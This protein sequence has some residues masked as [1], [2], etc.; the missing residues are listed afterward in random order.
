[1]SKKSEKDKA[2]RTEA[3]KSILEKNEYSDDGKPVNTNE[4]EKNLK[5][6][7]KEGLKLTLAN[8]EQL[9]IPESEPSPDGNMIR[10]M[11]QKREAPMKQS[12]IDDTLSKAKNKNIGITKKKHSK[13]QQSPAKTI[14]SNKTKKTT[15]SKKKESAQKSMHECTKSPNAGKEQSLINLKNDDLAEKKGKRSQS[16]N[17]NVDD[18]DAD[19]NDKNQKYVE[20][21]KNSRKHDS[22]KKYSIVHK[23]QNEKSADVPLA[24][25]VNQQCD[26]KSTATKLIDEKPVDQTLQRSSKKDK[27][28]V[29][30]KVKILYKQDGWL[31]ATI[32][33]VKRRKKGETYTPVLVLLEKDNIEDE[34]GYDGEKV[35]IISDIASKQSQKSN[36]VNGDNNVLATKTNISALSI[37]NN[38]TISNLE[39]VEE[40]AAIVL[41]STVATPKS[42]QQGKSPHP[43][44]TILSDSLIKDSAPSRRF[45]FD[46]ENLSRKRICVENQSNRSSNE[47]VTEVE[48]TDGYE[49][50]PCSAAETP[51]T[52]KSVKSPNIEKKKSSM[53][54]KL[55]FGSEEDG[56]SID[57]QIERPMALQRSRGNSQSSVCTLESVKES[58]SKN[59][60]NPPKPAHTVQDGKGKEETLKT[61]QH[62]DIKS[63]KD[64]KSGANI[65]EPK[66]ND[67]QNKTG[68]SPKRT[69]R[70]KRS[71]SIYESSNTLNDHKLEIYSKGEVNAPHDVKMSALKKEN[72][73]ENATDTPKSPELR[74]S[75]RSK[76]TKISD[77]PGNKTPLKTATPNHASAKAETPLSSQTTMS[78]HSN[79]TKAAD[80]IKGKVQDEAKTETSLSSAL[81]KSPRSKRAKLSDSPGGKNPLKTTA[82]KNEK[83]GSNLLG[84]NMVKKDQTGVMLKTSPKRTTR[85]RSS[86]TEPQPSNS[87]C[88][89]SREAKKFQPRKR[90]KS[91]D[92]SKEKLVSITDTSF[93]AQNNLDFNNM[94]PGFDQTYIEESESDVTRKKRK[95][96]DQKSVQFST[97]SNLEEI[98]PQIQEFDTKFNERIEEF[99]SLVMARSNGKVDNDE[100]ESALT[101]LVQNFTPAKAKPF[102]TVQMSKEDDKLETDDFDYDADEGEIRKDSYSST[103][104]ISNCS[105]NDEM[106]WSEQETTIASLQKQNSDLDA[107]RRKII[108]NEDLYLNM[109]Q[110]WECL[111]D[112]PLGREGARMM[113]T[114]GDGRNPKPRT[115]AAVLMVRKQVCVI[116]SY[117]T[118]YQMF[119]KV[120]SSS[121][122][123][124]SI[125]NSIGS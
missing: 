18:K 74:K 55:S 92:A 114:F 63:N 10:A 39:I 29:G 28:K 40:G 102:H 2:K 32:T 57:S 16:Q 35:V 95:L 48:M 33:Q 118:K 82:S 122:I 72:I 117:K 7:E 65:E 9:P 125:S 121:P 107:R 96:D 44:N 112:I 53:I 5:S 26:K 75:C 98:D 41:L 108:G 83:D 50:V 31:N 23:Q 43:K 38:K 14:D 60:I 51:K 47:I 70:T 59:K 11:K 42:L 73:I 90:T 120:F 115:V 15:P 100:I 68:T 123:K 86:K 124:L 36:S 54:K 85:S 101:E 105:N 71:R 52:V 24:K 109:M 84:K 94:K 64:K 49:V 62:E 88:E 111:D 3:A 61:P 89:P 30:D 20:T 46:G 78:S 27:P 116:L 99:V 87:A 81:R 104:N 103:K 69:S 13:I 19:S 113:V 8:I 66:T 56:K 34:V 17:E 77:S 22:N 21:D 76:K 106:K 37:E 119:G 93:D 4:S 12:S 25:S 80:S 91:S 1:M 79:R 110:D 58:V 45:S 6:S 97:A 67:L